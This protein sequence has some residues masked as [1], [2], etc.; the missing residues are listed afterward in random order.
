MKKVI[1]IL[2]LAGLLSVQALASLYVDAKGGAGGNTFRASDGSPTAW[3]TTTGAVD[4]LWWLRAATNIGNNANH[5][6]DAAGCNIYGSG[7]N[8]GENCPVIY[9]VVSGLTV[10]W[11]YDVDVVYW[12]AGNWPIKVGFATDN[13]LTYDQLGTLG[14]AG[15]CTG[16][17]T[18][19]FLARV[20]QIQADANGQIRVYI[21]DLPPAG[22][23]NRTWYDGVLVTVP[24]P[25]T[26]VM[27]S[28]GG[29]L[30]RRKR[31]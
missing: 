17:K 5:E 28:I 8:G 19:E 7:D 30:L 25:A 21:D 23:A 11:F 26:L 10:G 31:N 4:N 1:A 27:L 29:L 18:T 22:N 3:W 14:I 16:R 15:T 12:S 6:L 24:E 13:M 9:T 20:G 2:M